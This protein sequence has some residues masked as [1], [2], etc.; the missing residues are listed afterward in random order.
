[1]LGIL[2]CTL[3]TLDSTL[4]AMERYAYIYCNMAAASNQVFIMYTV[5]WCGY[6]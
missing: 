1:M 4:Q 6:A 5:G 3:L 2:L